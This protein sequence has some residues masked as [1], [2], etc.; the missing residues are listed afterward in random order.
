M[1]G[2]RTLVDLV[3]LAMVTS[4]QHKQVLEALEVVQGAIREMDLQPQVGQNA[5]SPLL[6]ELETLRGR[7]AAS[8]ALQV[9]Q[10][11]LFISYLL[12]LSIIYVERQCKK[13]RE[14]LAE[15]EV[16]LIEQKLQER[17]AKRRAAAAKAKALPGPNQE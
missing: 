9:V 15:E 3:Q 7:Q 6:V 17:K 14:R 11:L 10:F 1:Y 16:E 8:A 13:R 2:E 4:R 5:T 12:T